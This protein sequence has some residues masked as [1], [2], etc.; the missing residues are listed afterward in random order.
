MPPRAGVDRG[1]AQLGVRHIIDESRERVVCQMLADAAEPRRELGYDRVA[2]RL[3]G[4]V[5]LGVA[6]LLPVI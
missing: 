1:K 6:I 5:L 3:P 2:F 4:Q